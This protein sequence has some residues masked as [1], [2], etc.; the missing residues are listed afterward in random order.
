MNFL[1]GT[2][3]RPV[4]ITV[5]SR[6]NHCM[7]Q[8]CIKINLIVLVITCYLYFSQLTVPIIFSFSQIF[9]EII[10]RCFSRHVF[11]STFHAYSRKSSTQN[12]LL[13]FFCIKIKAGDISRTYTFTFQ[14][15]GSSIHLYRGKRFGETSAEIHMLVSCPSFR[16]TISLNSA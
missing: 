10:V 2:I 9:I 8:C 4:H 15:N 11:S 14:S 16:K 7:I 12:N 3:I 13:S 1:I 6:G 5:N